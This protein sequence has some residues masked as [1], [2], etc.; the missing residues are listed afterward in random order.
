MR[1][2]WYPLG[3]QNLHVG[4][5]LHTNFRTCH[6]RIAGMAIHCAVAPPS[7]R[8]D[9]RPGPRE[10]FT[11]QVWM[12]EIATAGPIRASR[13]WPYSTRWASRS[14]RSTAGAARS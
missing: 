8:A 2:I 4:R 7:E 5:I 13:S 14:S 12:D 10:W 6:I 3:A 1:R 11:G 9:T